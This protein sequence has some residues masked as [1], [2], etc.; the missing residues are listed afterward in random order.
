[1]GGGARIRGGEWGKDKG[2]GWD[3]DKGWEELKLH[4]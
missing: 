4:D 3:K 2:W 1:M